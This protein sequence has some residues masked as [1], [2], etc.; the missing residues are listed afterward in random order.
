MHCPC[1][2]GCAEAL[3][4]DTATA[5]SATPPATASAIANFVIVVC[6]VVLQV[7]ADPAPDM[8]AGRNSC[9]AQ[10]FESSVSELPGKNRR[11]NMMK[12]YNAFTK[13]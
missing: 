11:I 1:Q 13:K 12:S 6:M 8:A 7:S 4:N 2:R 3:V 10:F 9:N 5:L